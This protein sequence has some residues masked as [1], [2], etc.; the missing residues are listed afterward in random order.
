MKKTNPNVGKECILVKGV[1]CDDCGACDMCDLDPTKR[2]DNCMKCVKG[3]SEFRSVV[4]DGILLSE[5][6]DPDTQSIL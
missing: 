3:E 2:C 5:K 1:I 6:E 4:I